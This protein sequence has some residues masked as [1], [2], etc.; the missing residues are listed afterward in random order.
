MNYKNPKELKD[1][2]IAELLKKRKGSRAIKQ[3]D[4]MG[5]V[6]IRCPRVFFMHIAITWD[7]RNVHLQLRR[8]K[9][10]PEEISSFLYYQKIKT[11]NNWPCDSVNI[12]F[13][14]LRPKTDAKK[15]YSLRYDREQEAPHKMFNADTINHVLL[16]HQ[17]YKSLLFY[18]ELYKE[19]T[20]GIKKVVMEAQ[21]KRKPLDE[22]IYLF[23]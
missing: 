13:N 23:P 8:K 18:N 4:C 12:Y 15:P 5:T 10:V 14:H 19:I 21:A 11:K 20:E 22:F 6:I 16:A 3:N 17:L 9:D 1:A 7:S 2:I